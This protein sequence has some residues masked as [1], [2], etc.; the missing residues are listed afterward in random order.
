MTIIYILGTDGAGKSTIAKKIVSGG[1]SG[2]KL[3]YLYCQVR[4]FLIW[5][6]RRMVRY[7]Y[8]KKVDEFENYKVFNKKKL[9]VS[10]RKGKLST[11]YSCV[12]YLDFL[13]QALPKVLYAKM[14][15]GVILIDRYY[16]DMVVNQGVLKGNSKEEMLR[17]ARW[18]ER[19][20]PA[21]KIHI[22]LDV[23]ED[24]AFKRKSDI[25]STE[26]LAERKERYLN[27]SGYYN[28]KFVNANLEIDE[29]YKN[30]CSLISEFATEE[31]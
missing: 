25:Q 27:L 23:S 31:R 28:F 16:L 2:L 12:W 10:R 21:A 22:F 26:Y 9:T 17:E 3:S 4:P 8:I 1:I 24:V 18:I 15:G 19:L 11:L 29:V 7:F 30:V 5:P 20:L 6:I 14:K 13:I